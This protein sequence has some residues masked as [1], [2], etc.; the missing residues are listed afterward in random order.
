MARNLKRSELQKIYEEEYNGLIKETSFIVEGAFDWVKAAGG[1]AITYFL[2]TSEGRKALAD[3]LAAIPDLFRKTETA[4]D[5]SDDEELESQ[6]EKVIGHDDAFK[7][8]ADVIRGFDEGDVGKVL[9]IMK[10]HTGQKPQNVPVQTPDIGSDVDVTKLNPF[11]SQDTE[12]ALAESHTYLGNKYRQSLQPKDIQ[13][14]VTEAPELIPTL[15]LEFAAAIMPFLGKAG[16]ALAGW[17]GGGTAGATAAKL[18]GSGAVT[19]LGGAAAEKAIGPKKVDVQG[20]GGVIDP[21]AVKDIQ[22]QVG[23]LV[24]PRAKKLFDALDSSVLNPFSWGT[25]NDAVDQIFKPISSNK[26]ELRNIY[27]E[28]LAVLMEEDELDDGDLIDWLNDDGRED[29]GNVVAA[30]VPQSER[31]NPK[32]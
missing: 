32:S 8:A 26:N 5:E 24:T 21:S 25:D 30:V 2:T 6:A 3:I 17:L 10:G 14:I 11:I 27:A 12:P 4:A 22:K 20:A 7:T 9:A 13:F 1:A 31:V 15:Q 23:K 19:A 16:T 28:F 29:Y 18:A